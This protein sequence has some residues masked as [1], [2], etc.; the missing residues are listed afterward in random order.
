MI[1]REE[2]R[3]RAKGLLTQFVEGCVSIDDVLA[4]WPDDGP[5]DALLDDIRN[6]YVELAPPVGYLNDRE[7]ALL[8]VKALERNWAVK[9][10]SDA[11][12]A[13]G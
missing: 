12:D 5:Y 3:E 8:A 13:L 7:L 10:F 6:A 1:T 9:E 2:A 11:L 4:Q